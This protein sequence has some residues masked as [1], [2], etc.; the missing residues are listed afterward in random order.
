[1]RTRA[2]RH[3][4]RRRRS[5]R[6]CSLSSAEDTVPATGQGSESAIDAKAAARARRLANLRPPFKKGETGNPRGING[7]GK[8]NEIAAFLDKPESIGADR[9]R[10]EAIVERL[11]RAALRGDTLAARTLIEH[12]LGKPRT[13]PNALDLAEHFRRVERDKVDLALTILGPRILAMDPEKLAEFFKQCAAN[14]RGFLDEA[15]AQ[16]Q[17]NDPQPADQPAPELAQD[18]AKPAGQGKQPDEELAER[19]GD[20]V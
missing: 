17:A 7:R 15:E 20:D 1:L 11:F 6:G 18:E 10:F 9:T 14:P 12:K 8:A 5:T 16:E 3:D 4:S 2:K 13:T 19:P